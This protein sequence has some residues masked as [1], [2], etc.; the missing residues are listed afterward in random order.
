LISI[1][2]YGVDTFTAVNLLVFSRWSGKVQPAIPFNISR[3]IFAACIIASFIILAY[4]WFNAISAMRSGSITRSFL[5]PLAVRVQSVRPGKQG[6]GYRRF[7]VFA[8]L[9]K[10]RKAAEYIGL[11][12]YF[13]F[14]CELPSK[15]HWLSERF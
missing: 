1:A 8:E 3:W 2:V 9:T 14:R 6:R 15:V 10:D 13:S 7:L 4:R 12:A 11:F 5:D